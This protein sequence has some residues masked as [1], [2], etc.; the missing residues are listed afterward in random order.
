MG[1][2]FVAV[3]E[4]QAIQALDGLDQ[5]F[6]VRDW[7]TIPEQINR[8]AECSALAGISSWERLSLVA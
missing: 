7:P 6:E 8:L 2:C 4:I 1:L 5:A 3:E